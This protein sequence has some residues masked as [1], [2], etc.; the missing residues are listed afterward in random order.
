MRL[1][2]L[3]YLVIFVSI[4]FIFFIY[5]IFDLMSFYEGDGPNH[6]D[7]RILIN[8]GETL[9]QITKQL[10]NLGLL[11]NSEKFRILVKI[12][13]KEKKLKSGEYIVPALSSPK[14]IIDT[15]E[16]GKTVIHRITIVEGL[17]SN[18]IVDIINK[19]EGLSGEISVIPSEGSLLPDTYFFKWGESKNSLI[20]KMK[21]EMN[22]V[23]K[24]YWDS[25]TLNASINT[26][27]KAVILAS[28]IEKETGLEDERAHISSVFYNRLNIGMR[29]QSDPTVIY[30]MYVNGQSLEKSL[31]RKNI[32]T[33]SEY[34]TYLIK[35]L[36]KG[37]ICNPGRK[38][39]LAAL[40]PISSND[41][42]FVANGK[43][44][45]EFSRTLKEH[46]QNVAKWKKIKNKL[47]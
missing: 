23:V 20:E 28:I 41:L 21:N 14:K 27:F 8:K 47:N 30:G 36:P 17:K 39:I 11:T 29:L 33:F 40:N 24:K 43:G 35:G 4:F 46:N 26:P 45:H 22:S 44:G 16:N 5:F 9:N 12:L 32:K 19:T 3:R 7:V 34:N 15:L 25:R 18:Q 37:P 6:K 38:S 42:Y 2:K 10:D 1:N 31:T 13:S